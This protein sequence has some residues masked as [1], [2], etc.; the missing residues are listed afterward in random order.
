MVGVA[1]TAMRL[2]S[3]LARAEINLILIT[4]ASSEY[5][6]CFAVSPG[7][8]THAKDVIEQEFATERNA[9]MVDEVI[10][11]KNLSIVSVIGEE[12][13]NRPGIAGSVFSSLGRNGVNVAAIAQGSSELNIS[14]VARLTDLSKA[15]NA[16]HDEFFAKK[17]KTLNLVIIGVGL[18]GK[19]LVAQI[20]AHA[21]NLAEHH[22]IEVRICGLANTKRMLLSSSGIDPSD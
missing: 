14:T 5:T 22:A 2:F 12:M 21:D 7:D 20:A 4:Q 13:S 1:G 3:A 16:I 10:V 17:L 18:I 15:L 11:E 8:A 19:T 9:K 6:I